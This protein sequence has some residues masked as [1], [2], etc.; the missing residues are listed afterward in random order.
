MTDPYYFKC[1]KYTKDKNPKVS[2]IYNGK[3]KL[4]FSTRHGECNSK[5]NIKQNISGILSSLGVKTLLSKI[6]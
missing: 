6:V 5:K 3:L 4:M 1:K 2:N